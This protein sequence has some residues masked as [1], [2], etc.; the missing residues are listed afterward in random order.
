MK[1]TYQL[2]L[3]SL[4]TLSLGLASCNGAVPIEGKRNEAASSTPKSTATETEP[5]DLNIYLAYDGERTDRNYVWGWSDDP[6]LPGSL[7][8]VSSADNV[9]FERTGDDIPFIPVYLTFGQE[10]ECFNTWTD[11]VTGTPSSSFTLTEDNVL[12]DWSLEMHQV[13]K[14]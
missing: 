1:K 12:P 8:P 3:L 9:T 10:Y 14:R 11:D 6:S 5:S 2:T 4:V 7:F 13:I